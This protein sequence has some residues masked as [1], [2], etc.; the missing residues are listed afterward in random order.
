MSAGLGRRGDEGTWAEPLDPA[1]LGEL[2]SACEV[3][4]GRAKGEALEKLLW[5]LM[6]HVRGFEVY[7]HD[8]Y[9]DD[10]TQEVDLAIYN[11]CVDDFSRT[12]PATILVEAKN[13]DHPVGSQEVAWLYWKMKEGNARLGLLVAASGITGDAG[14]RSHALAITFAANREGLPILVVD[15]AEIRGL[16]EVEEI[17]ELIRRKTMALAVKGDPF[18]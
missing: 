12:Q 4:A 10:G 2:A 1:R 6:P 8:V 13:W 16:A 5:W 7:H 11:H 15:L 9:S 17:R 14:R 3:S 18:A